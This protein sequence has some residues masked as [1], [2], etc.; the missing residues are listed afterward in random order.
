MNGKKILN[1]SNCPISNRLSGSV[2]LYFH[3]PFCKK[4]CPYCHFYVLPDD[5][6]LKDLLL[7]GFYLEW[8]KERSRFSGRTISTIYFGGGTPFLFGPKRIGQILDWI[9]RDVVFS[10]VNAEI[11]L[12]ANP[13]HTTIS[14]MREFA[15]CGINRVSFGVQSFSEPLLH[16]LGRGHSPDRAYKAIDETVEAGISNISIDLMYDLPDQ[17]V[18]DWQNTLFQV[19]S[20]PIQHLSLY[21]LTF[22]PNT[23]FFK[24]KEL[25][26]PRLPDAEAS[27]WMY[28]FAIE[29]L[30]RVGLKQYEIS[31]F[32]R[33]GYEAQH[34]SGYWQGKWFW[35]FG[36]SAYSDWE[37]HRFNHIP[38]LREYVKR[39]QTSIST[40]DCKEML[41]LENRRRE[42]LVLRL[43]L[44]DGVSLEILVKDWGP[45]EEHSMKELS[46]LEQEGFLYSP[47][48]DRIALTKKG[49]FF[50]NQVASRLI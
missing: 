25:F 38:N 42:S 19:S 15:T 43:R 17:T 4:K 48:A 10:N 5:A 8:Q 21:N 6:S 46:L 50:F 22:E 12:E 39:L 7:E 9:H 33:P 37:E 30:Q 31:A 27:A 28:E 1:S 44:L 24:K 29:Q 49:I 45:L 34:N 13:E 41:T 20:L 35:G 26:Q 16:T 14:L 11:T 23:L 47:S 18:A 2:G 36:P 32:A 3:I 40:I